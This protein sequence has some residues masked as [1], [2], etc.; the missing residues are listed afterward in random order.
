MRLDEFLPEYDARERHERRLPATPELAVFAAVTLVPEPDADDTGATP[1]TSAPCCCDVALGS[2]ADVSGEDVTTGP[3]GLETSVTG[4]FV[5]TASAGSTVEPETTAA[6][7]GSTAGGGGTGSTVG[8][9]V[10]CVSPLTGASCRERARRFCGPGS[11]IVAGTESEVATAA[12]LGLVVVVADGDVVGS[13]AAVFT[14]SGPCFATSA[15]RLTPSTY[16]ITR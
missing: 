6:T 11:T 4:G 1:S 14:S 8:G 13:V 2:P 3:A 16:S 15:W 12:S 7:E 10:G 9:G 5:T